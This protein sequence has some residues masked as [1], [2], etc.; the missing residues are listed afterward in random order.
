MTFNCESRKEGE[1][2]RGKE[3]WQGDDKIDGMKAK[4]GDGRGLIK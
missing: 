4:Q 3:G 1:E 2:R